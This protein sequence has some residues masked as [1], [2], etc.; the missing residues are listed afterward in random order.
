MRSVSRN[1]VGNGF[2]RSVKLPVFHCVYCYLHF[3]DTVGFQCPADITA[4]A[5][6]FYSRTISPIVHLFPFLSPSLP[7]QGERFPAEN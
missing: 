4:V 6:N 7:F 5:R 2:D 3:P 1:S